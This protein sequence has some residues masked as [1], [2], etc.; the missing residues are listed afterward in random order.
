MAKEFNLSKEVKRPNIS[1]VKIQENDFIQV[2]Y[3]EN[4]VAFEAYVNV[5]VGGTINKLRF[6]VD[7]LTGIVNIDVAALI[8]AKESGLK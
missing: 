1:K 5:D 4:G 6:M 3:D 2:L 7:E 8:S